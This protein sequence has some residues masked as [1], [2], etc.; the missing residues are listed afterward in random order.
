MSKLTISEP[1]ANDH[2][3]QLKKYISKWEILQ[4]KKEEIQAFIGHIL[5]N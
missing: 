2:K 5:V 4:T 1:H 3:N